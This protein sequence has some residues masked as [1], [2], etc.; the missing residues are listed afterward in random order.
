MAVPRS[1]PA[2]TKP[3]PRPGPKPKSKSKSI[4]G[5]V[6]SILSISALV[7]LVRGNL[8]MMALLCIAC[9]GMTWYSSS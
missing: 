1:K 4:V 8:T 3:A 5:S 2:V 7:M 6:A 9:S